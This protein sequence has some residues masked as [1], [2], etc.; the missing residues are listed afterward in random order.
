MLKDLGT[1]EALAA[2]IAAHRSA[3]PATVT[4][5]RETP[6]AA[7]PAPTPQPSS[8]PAHGPFRPLQ[9]ELAAALG[10]KQQRWLADFIIRYN[11]RTAASK[12]HTQENRRHFADPRAVAGFKQA[13]KEIVYPIVVDRSSGANLRDIDGNEWIDLTLSF[14]AAMFGHQPPF[15]VEAITGQLER[16]MEI[17][18]TSPL[19]GE[20]AALLCE[21]TGMER[22]TFCNTGSEAVTGALRIART[23]TGRPRIVYFRESYHGISDEVLGRPGAHG[24]VPI[25]PG[26]PAGSAHANALILDYGDPRS[27]DQIVASADEIAAVLVEPVQSRR[28]ERQPREFLHALRALTE[29]HGMALIFDEIISGFRCHPGGAQAF[30]GVRADIATFGKVMG[31][32]LPI[33]AIAGRAEYLDAFDGGAWAFGDDSFPG[34][35]MTFFA[36]TFVRHPLALAAARAVLTKL[37]QDGPGLQETLSANAARMIDGINRGAHRLRPSPPSDFGSNWLDP[38]RAG[39]FGFSGLLY[40]LLRHRGLH[41]WEN[42]PC[43][44][45]TAHSEADVTRV[46]TAFAESAAELEDAGFFTRKG[47]ALS[48]LPRSIPSTEAQR[49]VW[50]LCQQSAMANRACNVSWT[51][52]LN[53][54]LDIDALQGA[55][56]AVVNR[57][58]SLRST[59]DRSGEK[60]IVA[61]ELPITAAQI[62]LSTQ[63]EAER[64][65]RY[66]ELLAAESAHI[67]NLERGPLVRVQ[68]V[69]LG[70]E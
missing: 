65:K 10:P 44:L 31:G 63:P 39:D 23:V 69:R 4:A 55:I 13:W 56:Q 64:E 54:S 26:I 62:D 7:L 6:A 1:L 49:E 18:P 35:A 24:A 29:K 32:G 47:A 33:G 60:M 58:E 51:M 57:H 11:T 17:G 48:P 66:A 16:G 40:A 36:G 9:P 15:I 14:G 20:V 46:V 59:F 45:S 50:L 34:A 3:V 42:R 53:G 8:S 41:V 61:P 22:A 52:L 21:L 70:Q 19:A 43:F 5:A 12:R 38:D 27:L 25:A 68:L 2:H 28:P 37:K 67:F 30:F